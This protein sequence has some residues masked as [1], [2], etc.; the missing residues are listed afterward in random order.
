MLS[1]Q[2][3]KLPCDP[4]L[5]VS[6]HLSEYN[7]ICRT[8]KRVEL[9]LN[10]YYNHSFCCT[11]KKVLKFFKKLIFNLYISYFKLLMCM[12]KVVIAKMKGFWRDLTVAWVL[13]DTTK[14][15][16]WKP[17]CPCFSICFHS[18]WNR[19]SELYQFFPLQC[20]PNVLNEKRTVKLGIP[21]AAMQLW[22][23]QI[24]GRYW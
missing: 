12:Q 18:W 3:W 4:C 20:Q 5:S 21:A 19:A 6:C 13:C 17:E 15:K 10:Y 8:N 1:N 24:F 23:R 9:L 16:C 2:F 22:L 7:P 11:Q 14:A